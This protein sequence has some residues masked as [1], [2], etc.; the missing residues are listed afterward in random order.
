MDDLDRA[1]SL[2]GRAGNLE[3]ATDVAR[4]DGLGACCLD[5]VE[6]ASS[7]PVR[8]LGLREVV[9]T[10]GTAADLALL[11]RD[12]FQFWDHGQ[13]SPGLAPDLLGMAQ[14]AGVVIGRL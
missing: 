9:G 5:V 8:H 2:F 6:L 13:E 14:V 4:D 11:E 3:D 10:R 1:A 7:E 12:N